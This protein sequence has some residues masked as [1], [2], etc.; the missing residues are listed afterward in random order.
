MLAIDMGRF[1]R[2]PT[3]RRI[4]LGVRKVEIVQV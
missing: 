4:Q 2:Q 3:P 1:E